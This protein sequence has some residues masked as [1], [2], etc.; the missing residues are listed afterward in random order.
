MKEN[1]YYS[2]IQTGSARRIAPDSV[3][4]G[5]EPTKRR[6]MMPAPKATIRRLL[7]Q[8]ERDPG[9]IDDLLQAGDENKRKDALVRRGHLRREDKPTK[10]E[11]KAEIAILLS[12][13][14]PPP[15]DP[16]GRVV[17]WIG[18]VATGAAGAAAA[19]C[20]GD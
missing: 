11:I 17:E 16:G 12:T 6:Y 8:L 13:D 18:A 10:E 9:L 4:V 19:A 15:A 7:A 20:T 3:I 5:F 14:N 1:W 2:F